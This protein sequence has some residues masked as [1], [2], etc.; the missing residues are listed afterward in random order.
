V[1][2]ILRSLTSRVQCD[3]QQS[4]N[5]PVQQCTTCSICALT[6][7]V[8]HLFNHV[9]LCSTL[10]TTL[11]VHNI[12]HLRADRDGQTLELYGYVIA[13]DSA[14][15]PYPFQRIMNLA[16]LCLCR[17]RTQ[18]CRSTSGA[19]PLLRQAPH[20]KRIDWHRLAAAAKSQQ[21]LRQPWSLRTA[22]ETG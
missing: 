2:F 7:T 19:W 20:Q 11:S 1:C 10:G 18:V 21:C 13:S 14:G 22:V 12:Q 9:L 16:T 17:Q 5:R 4:M 3:N 6:V 15:L 8:K